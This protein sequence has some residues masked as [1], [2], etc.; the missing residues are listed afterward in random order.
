MIPVSL[1]QYRDNIGN[2]G[3]IPVEGLFWRIDVVNWTKQVRVNDR[4]GICKR[5]HIGEI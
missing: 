1:S 2:G 4:I 5:K 3:R